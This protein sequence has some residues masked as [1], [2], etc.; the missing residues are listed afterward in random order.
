MNIKHYFYLAGLN[1]GLTPEEVAARL[2]L[3][4]ATMAAFLT[5]AALPD[6]DVMITVGAMAGAPRELALRDLAQWRARPRRSRR[7]LSRRLSPAAVP[8]AGGD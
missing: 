8:L 3:A 4:P 2:D 7:R 1:Q 6:D 5:G